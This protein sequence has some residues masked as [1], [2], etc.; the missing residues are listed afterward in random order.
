MN[1][2]VNLWFTE[3]GLVGTWILQDLGSC[4]PRSGQLAFGCSKN[5]QLLLSSYYEPDPVLDLVMWGEKSYRFFPRK[6]TLK[7]EISPVHSKN[8]T[9]KALIDATHSRLSK[10][11]EET[12]F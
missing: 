12:F 3:V 11:M 10:F 1:A 7:K 6:P 4:G 9:R 8:G 2:P 5:T